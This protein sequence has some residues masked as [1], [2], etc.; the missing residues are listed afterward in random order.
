MFFNAEDSWTASPLCVEMLCFPSS[1]R[2]ALHCKFCRL[3]EA[4][5]QQFSKA[6]YGQ[7]PLEGL[8]KHRLPESIARIPDS[9]GLGVGPRILHF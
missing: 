8:F 1:A 7:N 3:W 6:E 2:S 5:D 9:V 4:L